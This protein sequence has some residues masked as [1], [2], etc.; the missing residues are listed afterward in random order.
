V[1][2]SLHPRTAAS[3]AITKINA[4]TSHTQYVCLSNPSVDEIDF[5]IPSTDLHHYYYKDN[6][7]PRVSLTDASNNWL[8]GTTTVN[9]TGMSPAQVLAAISR[10]RSR[11]PTLLVLDPADHG[12]GDHHQ[13]RAY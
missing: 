2:H 13:Y 12:A 7:G 11:L 8:I 10:H 4:N 3:A 1:N 9:D 5:A 6:G